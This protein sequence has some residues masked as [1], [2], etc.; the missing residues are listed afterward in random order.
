MTFA[1]F[2]DAVILMISSPPG[3]FRTHEEINLDRPDEITGRS[4]SM[5]SLLLV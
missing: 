1:P 5:D 4:I 3:Q 2:G